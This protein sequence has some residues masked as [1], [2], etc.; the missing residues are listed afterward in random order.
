MRWYF[1]LN[2]QFSRWLWAGSQSTQS[3]ESCRKS[4]N[5]SISMF[6]TIC[7]YLCIQPSQRWSGNSIRSLNGFQM[8]GSHNFRSG[9]DNANH[10]R[11]HALL[12]ISVEVLILYLALV[13]G[14]N[15]SLVTWRNISV[16]LARNAGECPS[17]STTS[18]NSF[19]QKM[20]SL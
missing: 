18:L 12:K 16:L 9:S 19:W 3:F 8:Q 4:Q 5:F 17:Q 1:I 2:T 7:I 20:C 6:I 14:G 11:F 15:C 10:L 13:P